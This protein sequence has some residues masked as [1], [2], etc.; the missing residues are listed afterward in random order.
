MSTYTTEE[1]EFLAK[2]V[3]ISLTAMKQ[4]QCWKYDEANAKKVVFLEKLH[5]KL[6]KDAEG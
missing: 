3:L 6:L 4:A 1:L 2:N 5:G